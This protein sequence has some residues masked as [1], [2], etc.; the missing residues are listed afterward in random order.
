MELVLRGSSWEAVAALLADGPRTDVERLSIIESPQ[1]TSVDGLDLSGWTALRSLNLSGNRIES[2]EDVQWPPLLDELNLRNNMLEDFPASVFDAS[3]LT[4]LHLAGNKIAAL[5][6][7]FERIPL[8]TKLYLGGNRISDIDPKVFCSLPHLE[9]LYLGG[10][11]LS[12]LPA[13]I[14]ELASLRALWLHD[15]QLGEIPAN[16]MA[17]HSLEQLYLHKNQLV[18]LP[19]EVMALRKLR[20]LSLRENPLVTRFAESYRSKMPSLLELA[21]RA[22]LKQ[23]QQQPSASIESLPVAVR[24]MFSQAH[25]CHACSTPVFS[26]H[27]SRIDFLDLCGAVHV[28]FLQYL[29]SES[30]SMHVQSSSMDGIS[31]AARLRKVLLDRYNPHLSAPVEALKDELSNWDEGFD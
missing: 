15:N 4:S 3:M 2:M 30:C 11:R 8:L 17:L 27:V 10:N 20:K 31:R 21:A 12:A 5:G 1:I 9:V 19:A 6:G 26:E 22:Y 28:P 24:H 16:V 23:Q 29:C 18:V 25:Q 13:T 7:S 14:G